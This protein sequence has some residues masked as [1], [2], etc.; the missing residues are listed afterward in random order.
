MSAPLRH[1]PV[2]EEP[3]R[4][5]TTVSMRRLGK[6]TLAAERRA[7]PP[8][9]TARYDRPTT[10]LDCLPGGLNAERPC[11]FASCQHHLALD[12]NER[13]GNI[14]LNF[15]DVEVWE[16]TETCALDVADEGERTFEEIGA[17]VNLTR[18]RSRQIIE[19]A[20]VTLRVPMAA[21]DALPDQAGGAQSEHDDGS[22]SRSDV[23]AL[24]GLIEM[25]FGDLI[26]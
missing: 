10:R 20:L 17:L 6:R 16:M 14:K 21:L 19:Q 4:R 13:N 8:A 24:D 2:L 1:L 26:P 5:A 9:M 18:E 23:E 22:G 3:R 7:Y 11:P 12:V 25:S 15:P